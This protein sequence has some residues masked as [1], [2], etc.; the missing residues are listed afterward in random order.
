MYTYEITYK[1]TQVITCISKW[2]MSPFTYHC[3]TIL[4]NRHCAKLKQILFYDWRGAIF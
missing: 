2:R 4:Y 3:N 1:S